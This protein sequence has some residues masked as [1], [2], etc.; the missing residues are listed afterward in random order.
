MKDLIHAADHMSDKGYQ[1]GDLKD[2]PERNYKMTNDYVKEAP[3]H[4]GY[5][6]AVIGGEKNSSLFAEYL[7]FK[8]RHMNTAKN[9]IQ[10]IKESNKNKR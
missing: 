1:V 10:F 6:D 2:I 8:E 3:Y 5:E 9:I 7:A 4:P